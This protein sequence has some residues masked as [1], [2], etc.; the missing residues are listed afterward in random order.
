M[1]TVHSIIYIY[2]NMLKFV[3]LQQFS[4]NLVFTAGVLFGKQFNLLINTGGRPHL[5]HLVIYLNI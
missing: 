3:F 5:S 2:N 4:Y 1:I